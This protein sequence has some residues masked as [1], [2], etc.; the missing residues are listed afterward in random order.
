[1]SSLAEARCRGRAPSHI[2]PRRARLLFWLLMSVV[3]SFVPTGLV[4]GLEDRGVQEKSRHCLCIASELS[5]WHRVV[6]GFFICWG[7]F[8]PTARQACRRH[9]TRYGL[10]QMSGPFSV[11][12]VLSWMDGGLEGATSNQRQLQLWMIGAGDVAH[13]CEKVGTST[14]WPYL[15]R[16]GKPG[17]CPVLTYRE[18]KTK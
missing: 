2:R 17:E 13:A 4:G 10:K 8:K 18:W 7:I 16:I 15:C 11:R 3:V 5:L 12:T 1:M 14:S 9:P 6:P